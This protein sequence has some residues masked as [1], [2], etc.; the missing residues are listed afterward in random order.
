MKGSVPDMRENLVYEY[1]DTNLLYRLAKDINGQFMKVASLSASNYVAK[2]SSDI[3]L[4]S[5]DIET[6]P[7]TAFQVYGIAMA[8]TLGNSTINTE[9]SGGTLTSDVLVETTVSYYQPSPPASNNTT[10]ASKTGNLRWRN[11]FWQQTVAIQQQAVN[12][13]AASTGFAVGITSQGRFNTVV[14]VEPITIVGEGLVALASNPGTIVST[15]VHTGIWIVGKYVHISTNQYV[16]LV[17]LATGQAI[18]PPSILG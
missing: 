9:T 1:L 4:N 16:N 3:V 2:E 8:T 7:D 13:G 5:L 6:S 12:L 10:L 17:A 11:R 15:Y 14:L 18:L